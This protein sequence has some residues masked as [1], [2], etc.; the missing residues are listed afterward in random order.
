MKK[1]VPVTDMT[2]GQLYDAVENGEEFFDDN[3]DLLEISGGLLDAIDSYQCEII[4]QLKE[5]K[6]TR[7]VEAQWTNQL[8]GSW[9]NG[10]WCMVWDDGG[11]A[12]Y[13]K[14]TDYEKGRILPFKAIGTGC[15]YDNANPIQQELADL[16]EAI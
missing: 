12:F 14:V 1:H 7:L 9:K 8:D 13:A 2:F 3:L 6:I 15:N 5:G 10:V 4:E 11:H 16:L